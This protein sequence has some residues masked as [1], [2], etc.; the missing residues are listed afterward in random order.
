ME[1]NMQESS[2]QNMNQA[3]QKA[4]GIIN[5]L[6]SR[7]KP[8]VLKPKTAWD[9]LKN[10]NETTQDFYKNYLIYMA[11]IGPVCGLIGSLIGTGF[12]FTITLK[13]Q[14]VSYGLALLM[15]FI[16]SFIFPQIAKMCQGEIT[17]NNSIRLVGYAS[18]A[19]YLGGF[20]G[21]IPMLSI[22]GIFLGLYSLY[23]FYIG[24]P[25]MSTVPE[26]QTLKFTVL[27]IVA[28]IVISMIIGFITMILF[29]GDIAS[30]SGLANLGS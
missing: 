4:M 23:T 28:W 29:I 20:L 10:K 15:P 26:G 7:A 30:Q 22:L 16:T 21:L 18:T 17:A 6:V 25:K 11:A 14:I 1:Q 13:M 9:E 2:S 24:V 19:T 12:G 3:S 8:I 27:A 5:D